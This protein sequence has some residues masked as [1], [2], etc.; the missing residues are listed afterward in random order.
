MIAVRMFSCALLDYIRFC[1]ILATKRHRLL[2]NCFWPRPGKLLLV[3]KCHSWAN[4][5]LFAFF[6]NFVFA[7]DRPAIKSS[8]SFLVLPII[9]YSSLSFFGLPIIKS[10]LSSLMPFFFFLPYA[11][12]LCPSLICLLLS[13]LPCL[14]LICLPLRLRL[15]LSLCRHESPKLI[16]RFWVCCLGFGPHV[17][18]DLTLRH[19]WFEPLRLAHRF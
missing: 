5:Y 17:L 6:S 1:D 13:L 14:S 4:R 2:S 12:L 10:S 16:R 11:D 9:K 8:S 3:L 7:L 18:T 19:W 15:C